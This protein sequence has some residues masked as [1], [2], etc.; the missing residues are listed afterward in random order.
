MRDFT[1]KH[2]KLPTDNVKNITFHRDHRLGE[3]KPE[4]WHPRP[5]VAKFEHFKQKVLVNSRGRE[6]RGKDF[7]VN[8][9]FSKEILDRCRILF[10]IQRKFLDGGSWAVIAVDK[11]YLNDKLYCDRESTL[12]LFFLL[13]LVIQGNII[14]VRLSL[15]CLVII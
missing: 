2:L 15:T 14:N 9:Q 7:S 4:N 1:K 10:P 3:K 12:W 13:S 5:T 6:L 8:N 11:L